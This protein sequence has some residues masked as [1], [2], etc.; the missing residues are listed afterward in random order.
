MVKKQSQSWHPEDSY[1]FIIKKLK[2]FGT[3]GDAG[4]EKVL[5]LEQKVQNKFPDKLKEF[6]SIKDKALQVKNILSS[7]YN[8]G[9]GGT[10]SKAAKQI[11]K[12]YSLDLSKVTPEDLLKKQETTIKQLGFGKIAFSAKKQFDNGKSASKRFKKE[13]YLSKNGKKIR[14]VKPRHKKP[15]KKISF[16][17]QPLVKVRELPSPPDGLHANDIRTLTPHPEWTLLL[18]ETGS[19]FGE[20]AQPRSDKKRELGRMVGLLLPD[21]RHGLK[22]LPEQWHAVEVDDPTE[23]DQVVQAI[24]DADCGVFGLSVKSLSVTTGDRWAQLAQALVEWIVRLLPLDGTTNIKVMIEQRGLYVRDQNWKLMVDVI[25]RSLAYSWPERA[26]LINLKI[27][28][29]SKSGHSHNGYVDALAFTW[30]Q[31]TPWSQRRLNDSGLNGTCLL[32]VDSHLFLEN[33]NAFAL[34]HHLDSETWGKLITSD[35]AK[36]KESLVSTLM[37]A[38]GQENQARPELWQKY[39]TYC[40]EHLDS[41]AINLSSLALQIDWLDRYKPEGKKLSAT[42]RLTWLT[43]KLANAN[44]H[45][46]TEIAWLDELDT[47]AEQIRIENAPMVCKADLHR[48]V[49]ATNR[50]AFDMATSA[51]KRWQDCDPAIPGLRYWAQV[52]SSLG[53][54]EA[55]R[56]NTESAI[57]HFN[58][59]L[60]AFKRLSDGGSL[61]CL[62]TGTYKAIASMDNPQYD[63]DSL[64]KALTDTLGDLNDAVKIL[65][66]GK[67]SELKYSHQLLLRYLVF[68]GD[69]KLKDSYLCERGNWENNTGHPWPLIQAYRAIFLYPNEKQVAL[70]T[71]LDGAALAFE[72]EQGPTL[73]LIGACLRSIAHKWGDP[74]ENSAEILDSLRKDLPYAHDRIDILQKFIDAPNDTNGREMLKHVL[75]FNFR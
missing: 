16:I 74:W 41:K 24:L 67:A 4:K 3:W 71:M 1:E 55:F 53:Q 42:L 70:E 44:H 58:T 57:I 56:G 9:A 51:L 60:D 20:T 65:A 21:N 29:I 32:S 39:L 45:G 35:D 15:A 22:E 37:D 64:K 36:Q 38:L 72:A 40:E 75:P 14:T 7:C 62:Q 26:E 46:A 69:D 27:G 47:L 34:G 54:H 8:L 66:E 49:Q 33:W 52:Q 6:K 17:N 10:N 11:C 43:V 23:I 68:H 73:H 48:A 12:K 61:D 13:R 5:E 25:K 19:D 59:A 28:T 63:T 18:D 50:F 30:A 2:K 31:S